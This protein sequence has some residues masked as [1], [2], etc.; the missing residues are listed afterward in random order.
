MALDA[1]ER[2]LAIGPDEL[3]VGSTQH[4]DVVER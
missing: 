3:R 1:E 4:E 2:E